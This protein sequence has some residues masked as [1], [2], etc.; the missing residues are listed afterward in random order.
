MSCNDVHS[1][2]KVWLEIDNF[3]SLDKEIKEQISIVTN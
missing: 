1:S 2:T 3:T